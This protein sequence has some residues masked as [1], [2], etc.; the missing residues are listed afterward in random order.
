MAAINNDLLLKMH[1][2]ISLSKS[3][4]EQD[5]AKAFIDTA[6]NAEGPAPILINISAANASNPIIAKAVLELEATM[7]DTLN[8]QLQE[9]VSNRLS[10]LEATLSTVL[11]EIAE[12]NPAP[13]AG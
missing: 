10:E 13:P 3:I 8:A 9:A 7:R 11:N 2:A 1:E 4:V 12:L 5:A 6:L